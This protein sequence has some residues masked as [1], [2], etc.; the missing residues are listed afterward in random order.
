M[1]RR[2]RATV[3][4]HHGTPQAALEAG[5]YMEIDPDWKLNPDAGEAA[6]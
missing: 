3:L 5:E 1:P 6:P 2:W 4:R